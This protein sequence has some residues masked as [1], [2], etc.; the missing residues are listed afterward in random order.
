MNSQVLPLISIGIPTY[1]RAEG[2]L[3][4]ALE[5]ALSQ[6][7]QNI[8]IIVADNC[9]PDNTREVVQGYDD[10]R[11]RYFHH[12]PGI[13]PNDNFNFCL[14]Q[15]AGAYF[16]MLHDDDKVDPDFIDVCLRA[17]NYETHYGVIR[18]GVRIINAN[19]SILHEIRNTVGGASTAELFFGWFENRTSIY[20]CSTMFHTQGLKDIGGF[21]SLHNVYQD[22]VAI[23]LLATTLGRVDVEAVKA[24][25]R[26]HGGKWTHVAKVK[27]WSED[28][29]DLLRQ[30]CE[31][32]PEQAAE[33]RERGMRFFATVNY[34]RA[35]DIRSLMKRL[36]GYRIVYRLFGRRFLPPP[37]MVFQ[38]TAF[39]R[40]L[41]HIKRKML[42]MPAWVD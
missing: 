36:H 6:T 1:N 25:T 10:P 35:S 41:R 21:K 20:F 11:I 22:V 12:E 34:L 37:R 8:E 17:A 4:E 2:F 16:L 15:A 28:S 9:S 40:G 27:E 23:A 42:G 7:Y 39:Y 14:Q 13:T 32:V 33:L 5:C 30:L 19:G 24:S 31:L 38:S 29:L 26:Q 18:T 3:K